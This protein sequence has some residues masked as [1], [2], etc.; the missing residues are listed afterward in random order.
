M[1][2]KVPKIMQA[3]FEE[4]TSLT[5]AVCRKHLNNEYAEM[6]REMAAALA[7]KRP[8]PLA[9]GRANS[10]ACG[11]VYSVGFVNFLFDKSFPPYLS[12][13]DLCAAFGV[14]KGTGYNK[15]KEI[16]DL[17]DLMHFDPRWTLPSLMEDNPMAWMISVNGLIVDVRNAPRSIQEE[18]FRKGLIPYLPDPGESSSPQQGETTLPFQVGDSVM[19]K[20]GVQD[21]DYGDDMSGW[22][23]RVTEIDA[24]PPD[25]PLVTLQ[26]DS[27]TLRNMSRSTVARA[28]KEG[29]DWSTI[30][31]YLS[32]LEP[33]DPRDT[34]ADVESAL[35]EI[36]SHV[37]WLHLGD[38]GE[39][40]Q[41][42]LDEVDPDDEDACLEAWF[43]HFEKTLTFPFDAIL[44]ESEHYGPIRTGDTVR[45][46]ALN[47]VFED[48]GI[49]V[50]VKKERRTYQL[51]LADLEV[52][53]KHAPQ[54]Q[55]VMD[56]AVWF[57]NR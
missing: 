34:L 18:A 38:E 53:D 3:R 57:A 12:A 24:R 54:Y 33:V 16:R 55:P 13:E 49:L 7:R 42:V 14:A 21:P 48:Y 2:E 47:E 56:Y 10:W 17:L 5:D 29:L 36:A 27:V 8:S 4:I 19:V 37:A 1:N 50:D 44:A 46:I 11:I 26:W 20:P 31:L 22:Q 25:P 23:G 35:A 41:E 28:T 6:S 32:E 15:S 40:I 52:K 9:G 51:P 45:V 30:G 43:N 39:R